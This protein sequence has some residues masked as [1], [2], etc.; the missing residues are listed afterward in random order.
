MN[1]YRRV[2]PLCEAQLRDLRKLEGDA[3]LQIQIDETE[4][5]L[6]KAIRMIEIYGMEIEG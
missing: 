5:K 3:G 2:K 1:V 4:L 6:N